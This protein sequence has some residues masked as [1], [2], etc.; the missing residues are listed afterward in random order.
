MTCQ[1]DL[2]SSFK[3]GCPEPHWQKPRADNGQGKKPKHKP[4]NQETCQILSATPK[5]PAL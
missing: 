1:F 5:F 4:V 3:S 2:A